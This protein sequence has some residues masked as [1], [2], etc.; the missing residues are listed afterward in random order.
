MSDNQLRLCVQRLAES[1]CSWLGTVRPDNRAH[2]APIWHIWYRGRLYVVTKSSAVKVENI[3]NNPNVVVTHP[4]PHAA[5]I[6]EGTARLVTGIENEL[7]PLFKAKYDWDIVTDEAYRTVVEI[8]PLKLLAWGE[9]GAAF[10]R[11][12]SGAEIAAIELDQDV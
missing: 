9:E 10:G 3:R 12:W 5:I 4:D 6:L 11:R 8:T 1:E 7:R 2:S